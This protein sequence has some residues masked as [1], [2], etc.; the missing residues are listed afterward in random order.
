MKKLAFLS[1]I[2]LALVASDVEYKGNIGFETQYLHHSIQD[3]R[4]TA[5]ALRLEAELKKKFQDS[6]V[7]LKLKG[8]LDYNDKN[9][10]YVDFNDL[11]Y[12]YN[13]Q[14]SDLLIGR[15]TKFWGALEFYNLT[16]VFN[17]KD[18][19]DDP[20]DYDSKLGAWN[21]SYTNYF[22][23]SELSLIVKLHEE[24]QKMQERKSV[25]N[26]LPLPYND[27]LKTQSGDERPSIYLKYS[28]SGDEVQ[29]DYGIIYEN[30]YDAQRY[31]TM[32]G[33]SLQQNA[34]IVNKFL[35]YA[36]L[37]S[38]DTLYKTEMAYTLSE[39]KAVSDYGELGVGLEY[40][41]YGVWGQRDLGFLVEYYRYE[42]KDNTKLGAKDFNY[43]F[44][45]DISLGFRLSMNDL[46]S[47]ELLGGVDIDLDNH[48]KIY[49]LKYDTRVYEKYKLQLSYLHLSPSE[50][51][52]FQRLDRFKLEF[53]YYF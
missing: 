17:T 26:F 39:D 6:E 25:N 14:E 53:G 2:P 18:I 16:D 10:R 22:D 5:L 20:Y 24:K 11:Y 30:G 21:V 33:G 32:S 9:R 44:Q 46:F 28:G 48:E 42:A 37:V 49:T 51:S 50:S 40:T 8:L 12:K 38:G 23:N 47:S 43:F 4:D 7:A 45:N 35:G 13:F 19:L 34:Y 29:I 41:L 15:N 1:F 52:V 27:T 3:K 36:T 31:M